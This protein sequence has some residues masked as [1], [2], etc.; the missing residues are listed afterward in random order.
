MITPKINGLMLIN[1][2]LQLT[3]L[4]LRHY[5]YSHSVINSSNFASILVEP[6][7]ENSQYQCF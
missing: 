2:P 3:A 7:Q 6:Q 1:G 5:V 4:S